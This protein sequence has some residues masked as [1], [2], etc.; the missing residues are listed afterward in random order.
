LLDTLI[1]KTAAEAAVS[2]SLVMSAIG[3]AGFEPATP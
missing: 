2:R 1:T 3:T